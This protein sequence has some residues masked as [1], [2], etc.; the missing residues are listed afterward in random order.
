MP[1]SSRFPMP[2]AS[3]VIFTVVAL[4]A[5]MKGDRASTDTAGATAATAS[6]APRTLYERLGGQP[7]ITS[8]VDSFVAR[9]A[10]DARINKKF[11]RSD[12]ARVKSML[13]DQICGSTGGP[14]AYGGRTMKE[15]HRGMAVTEGEFNAFV[16]D[17]VATLNSFN[18][19][20]TEQDELLGI[21]GSMK[22]DIVER[23]TSQ[24]G[25]ALPTSFKAAPPLTKAP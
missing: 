4:T 14:C 13:V 22:A 10:S 5:C 6:A 20:K 23:P 2:A 3:L 11:A 17:L 21:L 25:T 1:Y 9:V 18:V 19:P 8:V 16:E 7:A 15:A 12:I 24:T